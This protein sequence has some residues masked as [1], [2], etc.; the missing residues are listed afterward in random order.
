MLIIFFRGRGKPNFSSLKSLEV[1]S[2]NLNK[3]SISKK[4]KQEILLQ[5]A[6]KI[7]EQEKRFVSKREI[8][9]TFHIEIYNYF[10]NIFNLYQ[11]LGIEVPLRYCPRK[12]AITKIIKFIRERSKRG[13]PPTKGE[14]EGKF[15]IQI[16][17]YFKNIESIYEKADIDFKLYQ[18]RRYYLET[19][20]NSKAKNLENKNKIIKY[21]LSHHSKGVFVGIYHIQKNL[22]LT[23]YKYFLNIREAYK[24]AKINYD[25]P[26][27]IILGKK[28]EIVLTEI[29][30][31]LFLDIGFQINRIS[32]ECKRNPN[33]FEDMTL[34]DSEGNIYLV[35][36]KAYRKDYSITKREFKQ[37][38][39]YIE[40]NPSAKAIFITTSNSN[41]CE[42]DNI[43]FINGEKLVKILRYWKLDYH[44]EAIKWIQNAKVS[45]KERELHRRNVK[46][47]IIEYVKDK[48]YTPTKQEIEKFLRVDL[49]TYFSQRNA[50]QKLLSIINN[51]NDQV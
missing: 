45:T 14:I 13:L 6:K 25:R 38:L 22:N 34:Q 40:R 9:N 49:R 31:E 32:L 26:S 33:K 3:K 27:P 44:I 4:R 21:I 28:K 37:L 20:F 48:K 1:I 17:T 8:R 24:A 39:H 19:H 50:Y 11:N 30:K 2:M 46:D 43:H 47:K 23:F 16:Y 12:Y 41:K 35:E 7:F 5:Y 15:N 18:K 42:F 36:I 10:K 29:L 51:D